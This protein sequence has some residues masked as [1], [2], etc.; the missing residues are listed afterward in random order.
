MSWSAK[1]FKHNLQGYG[2][3][4]KERITDKGRERKIVVK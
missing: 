4:G 3:R 1:E 2:N